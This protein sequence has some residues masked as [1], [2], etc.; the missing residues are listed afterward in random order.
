M[1]TTFHGPAT[2]VSSVC[3][4][5]QNSCAFEAAPFRFGLYR[6]GLTGVLSQP[7]GAVSPQAIPLNLFPGRGDE[8]GRSCSKR[9]EAA[10]R[11]LTNGFTALVTLC[12]AIGLGSGVAWSNIESPIAGQSHMTRAEFD[13]VFA[14]AAAAAARSGNTPGNRERLRNI[15]WKYLNGGPI[16]SK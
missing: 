11:Q 3:G 14:A 15:G 9:R 4:I 16:A 5:E 2:K 10:L 1:G 7:I 8:P 13:Q 6:H 12:I